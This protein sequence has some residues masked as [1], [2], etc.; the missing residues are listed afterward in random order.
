MKI[1]GF[2]ITRAREEKA[3]N[4][5]AGGRGWWPLVLE[6]YTGAWQQNVSLD[7]NLILTYHAVYACM[8]LI[9]SDISKLRC[10]LV[11]DADEDGIWQETTNPAY[12]PVL[13]KPNNY[14]TRI[15]FWENWMLSKLSRGNT[16]GLKQRD[17]RG[18]VKRLYI[19]DPTRTRP[20]VSDEGDVFYE[21]NTDNLTGIGN[22]VVVPAREIIHDR[23]N[24][25]FHPLCGTSPIYASGLAATAGN[26][27][28][29]QAAWFFGNRS[30]PG[31]IL[32]APGAIKDETATRL[33]EAWETNF[34]GANTGRVAVLGDGLK[35]EKL[36]ISAQ[37]SQMIEQL[38]W[39]AE[40]VCSTFHV[41]PYKIGLGTM[42]TYNNIQALNTEYYSQCLQ[43][44]IEAAELCLDEGLDL[45][46][47][48][49]VEFDLEGLLRMDTATQMSVLKDGV[50][51]GLIAPNEGRARLGYGPVVGGA[52]PY[53]QQ[54]NY[55]LAALAKRDMREDPF[56]KGTAP[57]PAGGSNEPPEGNEASE[58]EGDAEA[59]PA[60]ERRLALPAPDATDAVIRAMQKR[61]EIADA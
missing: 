9:A 1:F 14:Q 43:A 2:S 42:P 12:S 52:S 44:L 19:L 5:V 29:T 27:M 22:Q 28:M 50:S 57:A 36:P 37:E 6:P 23:F 10:R 38:K 34:S 40:V 49:T 55:S 61:W 60:S 24:C 39:T 58:G 32:T 20:L 18:V 31:G 59:L 11:E 8:T 41:P 25:I 46:P 16:Y 21:L 56:A 15:Q 51:A 30:M 7:R 3:L 33:K 17:E 35:F 13:R 47:T 26:A 45:G 53:L 48:L 54:Q 4:S